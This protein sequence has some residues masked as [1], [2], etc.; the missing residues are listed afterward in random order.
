[1]TEKAKAERRLPKGQVLALF[2]LFLIVFTGFSALTIDYGS[3]LVA[4]RGYQ[5][6]ADSAVLAGSAFLTR[7]I[8]N[9]KRAQAREAA[10]ASLK[11]QLGLSA[12]INPATLGA[13]NSTAASYVTDSGYRIWVSTP[14]IAA[15]TR[16]PGTYTGATDR[17]LFAWV[18]KDNPTFFARIFGQSSATVS[19]WATAGQFPGRFAVLTLRQN[20]QD[21]P[22]TATDIDLNG[23]GTNLEVIDGDVG[24]N[25]AMK[26]NSS[27]QLWLRGIADNE[28]DVY[29]VDYTTC[30]S[31]C[32]SPNQINSGPN[33]FPANIQRT[34]LQLPNILDDP[35][36][37]LPAVLSGVP[38]SYGATGPI[39][40][41][42]GTDAQGDLRIRNGTAS[43][44]GCDANSPRIGP[45]WYHD[46]RVDSGACL[47]LD[48]THTYTDPDNATVASRGK[49][50]LPNAQ[51]PGIFY[52]TG[53]VN[54]TGGILVGDGVTVVLR[55][56]NAA[57]SPNSG[58][59]IDLNTGASGIP[60]Q[61]RGAFMT[62]GNYT[63]QWN[64]AV[65]QYDSSVN[66][67]NF[68]TGV[69]I[70]VVKPAQYGNNTVD[71]NTNTIQVQSGS[72]LAWS[73][74][75]YAPHDNIQIAGQPSHD[76]IGQFVSWTF[77]FSGG[78]AVKQT[79][80]GPDQALPRLV[81][82]HLGQ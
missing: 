12:A 21:G 74:V 14:P 29:L 79:Y 82:P 37:P 42:G 18:E 54:V 19:A 41:G 20:G 4:R 11:T 64:G 5:N 67:G 56:P 28:S 48:A 27:S 25:W 55:P 2:A 80:D 69:A 34:P 16:Y 57:L 60:N 3:W 17:Y 15:T 77:K 36:Y 24:G 46:L 78:V 43:G 26:L 59:V 70:Y 13:S 40:K 7:P 35:S 53:T 52:I 6:A 38:L 73:G 22:S 68:R 61:K 49:A 51:Q 66:N 47:V 75:T 10:W 81:E 65:W 58:G 50:D 39:Q 1:M 8:D 63:Y 9:T 23:S 33:G 45:G 76:G 44:R 62:D 71:A 32:W 72:G 30:G 31:S